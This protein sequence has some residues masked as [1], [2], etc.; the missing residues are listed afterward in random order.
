MCVQQYHSGKFDH[1]H[2]FNRT[3]LMEQLTV[4]RQ[5]DLA[6]LFKK[7]EETTRKEKERGDSSLQTQAG[8]RVETSDKFA[9]VYTKD[10][11]R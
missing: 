5:A 8:G 7:E 3:M 10:W 4:D 11:E 2:K 9:R 1:K 6:S